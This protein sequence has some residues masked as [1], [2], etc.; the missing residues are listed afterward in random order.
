[1]DLTEAQQQRIVQLNELDEMHQDAIQQ[2]TLV[3]QQRSKWH[4][5]FIQKKQFKPGD[6]ALLFYSKFKN[7]KG[8]FTT[9]WLG[10]YEVVNVFDNGSMKIKTIDGEG[11]SF[12]V[13]GHRLRLYKH[14]ADTSSSIVFKI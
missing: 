12:L 13:N 3:Q 7:F 8:K 11:I 1:M 10:P 4:D 9:Q 6:W 2:T 5:K 14:S